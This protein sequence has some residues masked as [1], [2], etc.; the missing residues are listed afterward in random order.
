MIA[1]R[2]RRHMIRGMRA[3][4]VYILASRSGVL[5]VGMTNDIARRV[6]QHRAGSPAGFSR[7]YH[8]HRLVHVEEA[9]TARAAI[10]REKQV[11][12]WSRAKKLALIGS[13]N[14][15]WSDLA[16]DWVVPTLEPP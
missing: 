12:G 14:P 4:Y 5:Y 6:A 3:Y 8:V 11:K 2:E 10:A 16:A 7:R 9:P 13:A 1:A 15:S